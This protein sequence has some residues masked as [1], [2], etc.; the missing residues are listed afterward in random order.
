[1]RFLDVYE[2]TGEKLLIGYSFNSLYNFVG[3]QYFCN[4]SLINNANACFVRTAW[5]Y[6]GNTRILFYFSAKKE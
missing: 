3:K 1:L 4:N 6:H 2:G 5:K